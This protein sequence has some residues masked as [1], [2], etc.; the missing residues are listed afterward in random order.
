MQQQTRAQLHITTVMNREL[1]QDYYLL[2]LLDLVLPCCNR[3]PSAH[4]TLGNQSV[5]IVKTYLPANIR[6]PSS[7]NNT[8]LEKCSQKDIFGMITEYST[9]ES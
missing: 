9:L 6:T 8:I 3:P 4:R 5:K 7:D 2:A 1:L